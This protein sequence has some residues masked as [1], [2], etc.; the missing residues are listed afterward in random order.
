[1]SEREDE[2]IYSHYF[3]KMNEAKKQQKEDQS[4]MDKEQK[5]VQEEANKF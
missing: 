1:M 5:L 4:K 2:D 3:N